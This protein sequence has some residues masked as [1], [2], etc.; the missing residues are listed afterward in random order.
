MRKLITGIATLAILALVASPAAAHPKSKFPRAPYTYV[1]TIDCG[2][3]PVTVGSYDDLWADLEDL[4]SRKRYRPV[5]WHV[6]V[7]ENSFD[8]VKDGRVKKHRTAC[9]YDDGVA[10]GTVVV[11]GKQR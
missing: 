4:D 11:E 10:T 1:A 7:G 6:T 5:E 3:G 8:E 2:S 9:S